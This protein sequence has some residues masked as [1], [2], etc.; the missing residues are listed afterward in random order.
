MSGPGANP[1]LRRPAA[2]PSSSRGGG[3]DGLA[4]VLERVLDKGLVI[5]GDIQINLLDIE[6]LTIKVRL[7]LASADTAQQMGIDWWKHDPFLSGRDRELAHENAILRERVDQLEAAMGAKLAPGEPSPGD[8]V[9]EGAEDLG[10][11]RGQLTPTGAPLGGPDGGGDG[12][13][14]EGAGE[15]VPEPVEADEVRLRPAGEDATLRV[16]E[17]DDRTVRVTAAPD[18]NARTK[19]ELQDEL[20]DRG[21]PVSGS[22]AELVERL[23]TDE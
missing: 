3:G 7:L 4:D 23:E 8:L 12:G 2:P 11:T 15:D 13:S 9:G 22:K 14:G 18:W 19:A 1:Y 16:S 17:D 6:L 21:L 10:P 5:A 20:R